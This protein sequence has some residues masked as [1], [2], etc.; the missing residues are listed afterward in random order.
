MSR[1]CGNAESKALLEAAEYWKENALLA[2]GSI[3]T[4]KSLWQLKHLEALNQFFVNQPD[5]GKGTFFEKLS[6]QLE[7]TAPEVKQLAAE[8]LWVMLLCPSKIGPET[9]REG[10][11]MIW[12]WS[13]ETLQ[14]SD[15]LTD[16]VLL[17]VGSAGVGYNTQRWR[18]VVFVVRILM[19]FKQ[20]EPED[21]SNLL[22]DGWEFGK[23]LEQI[24]ECESRQFRHMMLFMLFPDDFERIFGMTDR[25]QI[26]STINKKTKTQLKAMTVLQIDKE[27]AKIRQEQEK[28]YGTKELDFYAPPLSGLWKN[29]R[30]AGN[31]A[32]SPVTPQIAGTNLIMYGPPGTGKTYNTI[33]HALKILGEDTNQ[34]RR[35][36]HEL[37]EKYRDQGRIGFVTFHQSFSYEDFIEG[38]KPLSPENSENETDQLTYDIQDGIFK[39]MCKRASSS[40]GS[41]K[42]SVYDFDETRVRLY[43]MSLG[44]KHRWSIH[45]WCVENGYISMGWGGDNDYSDMK[46]LDTWSVFRD[47]FKEKYP[48][49]ASSKRYTIQALFIFM[50]MKEGDIVLA[51]KGNHK[52]DAVGKVTG[53]YEFMDDNPTEFCH[54][55]KVEWLLT[56]LDSPV[57]VFVKKNISQQSIYEFAKKDIRI[58]HLKQ[59]L[60]G[61]TET[62]GNYVL[63]IDEINRGNVAN[64]FGEIITLIEEDKRAGNREELSVILP[65]SKKEFSVP[66]NLHIIGTM[67]TA[68]RSVEALDSALRRRFKFIEKAPDPELINQPKNLDVDLQKLFVTLNNRIEALLDKDHCLGHSYFMTIDMADD[69]IEALKEVFSNKILPLLNEYFYGNPIKIGMVLGESFVE[70][71]IYDGGNNISFGK[72]FETAL[73]DFERETI[74][75]INDPM[76]FADTEPFKS[77]YE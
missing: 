45:E 59:I 40:A 17:G 32:K 35:V 7:P 73:E 16:D 65:Y 70:K 48:E 28:A 26:V 12:G 33:N 2:D 36:L 20:L 9:K 57:D 21:R 41:K 18:E 24:P 5:A 10:I 38:I 11:Q 56:D 60:S 49:L 58:E 15:W 19:A 13:G 22:K 53:G 71:K 64:I 37:F 47:T 50:N 42:D 14:N 67:N 76:K 39:I 62:P 6:K 43:K 75:I 74:Y 31:I 55:R 63:I 4:E 1:F 23:W 66:P 46:H 51:S 54:F 52:I 69:P 44:G 27:L 68:D 29:N 30:T 34:D 8:I 3:F 72:G 77:I 25:K 61:G